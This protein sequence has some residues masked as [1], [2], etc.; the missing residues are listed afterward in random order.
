MYCPGPNGTD[1]ASRLEALG[2]AQFFPRP[3]DDPAML[4]R[5][6]RVLRR[7]IWARSSI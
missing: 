6:A 7:P 1:L 3:L 5:L 2:A 4:P